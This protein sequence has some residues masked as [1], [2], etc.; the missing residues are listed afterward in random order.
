MDGLEKAERGFWGVGLGQPEGNTF[1][2]VEGLGECRRT[3]L[4]AGPRLPTTMISA[5]VTLSGN[6]VRALLRA[7][8]HFNTE[9]ISAL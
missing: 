4:R 2:F 8:G 7:F 9:C 5:R 6:N 1:K 3:N